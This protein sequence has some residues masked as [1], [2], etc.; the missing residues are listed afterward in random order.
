[1]VPCRARRLGSL[2]GPFA[3]FVGVFG[4]FLGRGASGLRARCC[5]GLGGDPGGAGRNPLGTDRGGLGRTRRVLGRGMGRVRHGRG[6]GALQLALGCARWCDLGARSRH[7]GF[8]A[9][10]GRALQ[11]AH[12]GRGFA[13]G[14]QRGRWGFAA[15]LDGRGQAGTGV[16]AFGLHGF[17][18][19]GFA[20]RFGAQGRAFLGAQF[21]V[22]SGRRGSGHGGCGGCV[23]R[24]G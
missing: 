7:S 22:A 8:A 11:G 4:G 19:W 1:M 5:V 24:L 16:V 17:S 10:L 20:R 3:S 12:G 21:G 14:A 2:R 9:G 18:A 13:Q 6:A 23:G 15:R